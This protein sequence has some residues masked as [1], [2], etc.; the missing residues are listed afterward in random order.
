MVPHT[1]TLAVVA[2]ALLATVPAAAQTAPRELRVRMAQ[3]GRELAGGGRFTSRGREDGSPWSLRWARE[4]GHWVVREITGEYHIPR[5]VLGRP[6]GEISRDTTAYAWLPEERRYATATEW[7]RSHRPVIVGGR[8]LMKYGLPRHLGRDEMDPVG[9]LGVVPFFAEKGTA[10]AP[11][12]VYAPVGPGEYQPYLSTVH[13]LKD[14]CGG[15][16]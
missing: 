4:R 1:F 12:V 10:H 16:R 2:A 8:W 3:L 9:R 6:I 7:Y 5:R 15:W 14:M 11:E 13:T